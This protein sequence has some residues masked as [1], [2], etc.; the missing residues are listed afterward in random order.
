MAK[1]SVLLPTY[2]DKKRKRSERIR[3]D[4][5]RYESQPYFAAIMSA[6]TKSGFRGMELRSGPHSREADRPSA[7]F[8]APNG[9]SSGPSLCPVAHLRNDVD[10]DSARFTYLLHFRDGYYVRR[11]LLDRL[12]SDGFDYWNGRPFHFPNSFLHWRVFWL[13][14][15][16]RLFR[17]FRSHGLA[18]LT[19]LS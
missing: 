17:R 6:L 3:D 10:S 16:N 1:F 11:L 2:R 15:G 13:R 14:F 8:H 4:N 18:W 19:A 5:L 12:N 7:G 9:N